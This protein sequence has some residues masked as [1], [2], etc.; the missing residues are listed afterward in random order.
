MSL[1]IWVVVPLVPNV[2][3]YSFVDQKKKKETNHEIM[4][5]ATSMVLS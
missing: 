5:A 1:C 3:I 4:H 2:N